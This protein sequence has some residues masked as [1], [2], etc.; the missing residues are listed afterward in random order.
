VPS[1][2]RWTFF[3]MEINYNDLLKVQQGLIKNNYSGHIKL[4]IYFIWT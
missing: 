1:S 4:L 2:Q 3:T